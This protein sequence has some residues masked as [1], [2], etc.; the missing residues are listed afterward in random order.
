[1]A[2]YYTVNY[3]KERKEFSASLLPLQRSTRACLRTVSTIKFSFGRISLSSEC[4]VGESGEFFL[5]PIVQ[6]YLGSCTV[7]S[8]R[9]L[10]VIASAVV[11]FCGCVSFVSA[12]TYLLRQLCSFAST[13]V[14]FCFDGCVIFC[15]GGC[16]IFFSCVI[17]FGGCSTY[18]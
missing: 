17:C 6:L 18:D 8:L 3:R 10:C 15:F 12:A 4:C 7:F 9:R 11:H 13:V 16:T 5:T 2:V 1:M 14:Q